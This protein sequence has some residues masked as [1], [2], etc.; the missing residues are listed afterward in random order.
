MFNLEKHISRLKPDYISGI[1]S[2]E[3]ILASAIAYKLHIGFI[4]IQKPNKL[5]EKY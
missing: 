5:Q 2:R 3:F 1:E 4:P